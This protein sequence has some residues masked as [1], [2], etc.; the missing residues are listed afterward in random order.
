MKRTADNPN[1]NPKHDA[2]NRLIEEHFAGRSDQLVP[3]SGFVASVMESIQAEAAAPPPIVFP[4]RR[5]L[6]GAL[7]A[8]CGL[9]VLVVLVLHG[10]V[11]HG[12]NAALAAPA[13][14]QLALSFPPVFSAG[15]GVLG[16]IL[17][18]AC[19]SVAAIA[20]SFRLT[21]RSQ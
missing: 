12:G 9:I 21:G 17:V 13:H 10:D 20:A 2:L 8:L 14:A 16:W 4:W 7:V 15:D 18:A 5:V 6:P 19:L 1:P 11:L 3:S